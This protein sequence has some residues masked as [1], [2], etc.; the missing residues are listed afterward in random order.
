MHGESLAWVGPWQFDDKVEN[1][2]FAEPVG[3]DSGR[4]SEANVR[5]YFESAS[6]PIVSV[7]PMD[8][9]SKWFASSPVA[10]LE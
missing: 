6:T 2:D 3:N 1:C 5:T 8:S 10:F 9:W 4:I 7:A